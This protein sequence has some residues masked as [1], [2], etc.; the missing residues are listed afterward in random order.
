MEIITPKRVIGLKND[1]TKFFTIRVVHAEGMQE[2]LCPDGE[3]L[4]H[5]QQ[6][7]KR[8]RYR[9]QEL[10]FENRLAADSEEQLRY[11]GIVN[12]ILD[13]KDHDEYKRKTSIKYKVLKFLKLT[14]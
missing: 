11:N 10:A 9:Q 5:S 8:E 6:E 14:K 2:F 12:S 7:R 1:P 13:F 4:Y 3:D